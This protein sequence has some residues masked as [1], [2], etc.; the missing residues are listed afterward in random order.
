MDEDDEELEDVAEEGDEDQ[1]EDKP[2]RRKI[3]HGS[4]WL[5]EY[6]NEQCGTEH[7]AYTLRALIRGLVKRGEYDRNVGED[8]SRYEFTGPKDPKVLAVIKAIK[9]GAGKKADKSE[10]VAN[11]EKARKAKAAKKEAAEKAKQEEETIEELDEDLDE[12][13]EDI[14][15]LDEDE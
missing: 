3:E 5:A 2:A 7:T 8:R 10:R 15:D 6:V 12:D 1:A 9:A 11:L 4:A 13:I 14:D